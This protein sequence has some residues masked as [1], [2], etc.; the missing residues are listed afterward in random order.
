AERDRAMTRLARSVDGVV[1]IAPEQQGI[2]L[3]LT[4]EV[5]RVGGRLFSP[6]PDFVGITSDK[7]E[8][9]IRLYAAGVMIPEGIVLMPGEKMPEAFPYPGVLKPIDGAGSV[10][11]ER[12]DR[13]RRVPKEAGA[14]RLER[15]IDG[16]PVTVSVVCGPAGSQPLVPCNQFLGGERGFEYLGGSLPV[17]PEF[18]ER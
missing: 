15:L 5:E 13:P 1:L 6:G 17:A 10:G 14:Y 16:A 4:G 2:L 9:A 3:R 12:I 8:T 11:V 18:V 7:H